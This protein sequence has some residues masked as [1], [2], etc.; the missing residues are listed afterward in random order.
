MNKGSGLESRVWGLG[1]GGKVHCWDLGVEGLG[2]G[3]RF[4]V[5]DIFSWFWDLGS[6]FGD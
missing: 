6:G 1:F 3:L 5:Q 4:R 2:S